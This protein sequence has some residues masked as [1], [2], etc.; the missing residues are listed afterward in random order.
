[1]KEVEGAWKRDGR[2]DKKKTRLE[3]RLQGGHVW[4]CDG[5]ARVRAHRKGKLRVLSLERKT[6]RV[7]YSEQAN[8]REQRVGCAGPRLKVSV[9]IVPNRVRLVGGKP[10]TEIKHHCVRFSFL[11]FNY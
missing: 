7:Q 5:V 1:M 8:R 9:F 11:F 3:A 2:Q 6:K 4:V 10:S